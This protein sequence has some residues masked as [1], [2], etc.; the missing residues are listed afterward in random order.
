MPPVKHRAR[1]ALEAFTAIVVLS[2]TVGAPAS[3]KHHTP[4]APTTFGGRR[5]TRLVSRR[6]IRLRRRARPR[7][8]RRPPSAP[9][10][11]GP[12]DTM[13]VAMRRARARAMPPLGRPAEARSWFTRRALG[14]HP[15][16]RLSRNP[17]VVCSAIAHA[18][19]STMGIRHAHRAKRGMSCPS[20]H[21]DLDSSP[22]AA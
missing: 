20:A 19:A 17:D 18:R 4:H 1:R 11:V 3:T 2:V 13:I 21:L 5:G 22:A 9:S 12:S 7:R 14:V 6:G 16:G 15:R 10:T 8:A